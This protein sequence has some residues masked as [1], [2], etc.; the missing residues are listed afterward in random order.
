M[1]LSGRRQDYLEGHERSEVRQNILHKIVL[2]IYKAQLQACSR[3][4]K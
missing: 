1:D 2:I 4:E 3:Q